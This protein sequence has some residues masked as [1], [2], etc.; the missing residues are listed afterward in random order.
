M[1]SHFMYTD[2]SNEITQKMGCI[3]SDFKKHNASLG[4][5]FSAFLYRMYHR[6]KF[7]KKLQFNTHKQLRVIFPEKKLLEMLGDMSDNKILKIYPTAQVD[8]SC[9]TYEIIAD[10]FYDDKIIKFAKIKDERLLKA[11]KKR[12][13]QIYQELPDNYKFYADNNKY[14]ELDIEKAKSRIKKYYEYSDHFIKKAIQHNSTP[15]DVYNKY[16]IQI[17]AYQYNDNFSKDNNGNRGYSRNTTI[18]SLNIQDISIDGDY[19][20]AN[21]DINTSQMRFFYLWLA[22]M[23]NYSSDYRKELNDFH[24]ILQENDKNKDIYSIWQS[25]KHLLRDDRKTHFF[26]HVI[27]R[28]WFNPIYNELFAEFID[29]FPKIVSQVKKVAFGQKKN[30]VAIQMQKMESD[31]IY[32]KLTSVIRK[33]FPNERLTTRHDSIFC[34]Q[35]IAA[36]IEQ[37]MQICFIENYKIPLNTHIEY[38]N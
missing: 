29:R 4:V 32:N 7:M 6:N 18:N 13:I 24:N 3:N 20:T 34:K 1:F 2:T 22:S 25:T 23:D 31:F 30:F 9:N 21:V 16:L 38:Y 10:G 12:K 14:F 35:S 37:S 26:Q 33:Y 11:L 27:F 28:N 5:F 15:D 17:E 19:Q 8:V 36:D